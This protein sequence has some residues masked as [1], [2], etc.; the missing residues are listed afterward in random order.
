MRLALG[1]ALVVWLLVG[2]FA[3]AGEQALRLHQVIENPGDLSL[4]ERQEL[5]DLSPPLENTPLILF[6]DRDNTM[7][8]K[9]VLAASDI[10]QFFTIYDARTEL[11]GDED[12]DGF[13]YRLRV[14]FDADVDIGGANVY[15][16]LYLS[17]EGGPWNHIFTTDVFYILEDSYYDDYEVVTQLLEGYPTGYYDLLIELYDADWDV[18]VAEY[19]PFEDA[20]LW[21]LPLEDRER[22]QPSSDGGGGGFGWF[23]LLM[24]GIWWRKGLGCHAKAVPHTR[25]G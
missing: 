19:G 24:L 17:Y 10:V 1:M 9:E 25:A 2:P 20:A 8:A 23:G 3:V 14:T 7:A 13:Y 18:L 22:D 5:L 11:S 21:A 12:H 6:G 4:E 16:M 15:A